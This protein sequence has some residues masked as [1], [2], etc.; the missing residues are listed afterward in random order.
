MQ[1]F[2]PARA[3]SAGFIATFA[4]TLM[5][6]A[7]PVLGGPPMDFAAMLGALIAGAPP[8]AWTVPWFIGMIIHFIDGSIIF[9]L[10]YAYFLFRVL[11]GSHGIKGMT[12]GAVL[13]FLSQAIVTPALGGGFFAAHTPNPLATVI[14][15][16]IL[17]LVY[18]TILGKM[19]A[20]Q[21]TLLPGT[22]RYMVQS[23]ED[24]HDYQR[25]N[26]SQR[27]G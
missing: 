18:G 16:L 13:W 27:L 24:S 21:A 23:R 12:W 8:N 14:A 9:P 25:R 15:N 1:N 4:M 2:N 19:A 22:E 7:S 20:E 5:A 6:Y 3:M 26:K 10:I 11:P 17:H